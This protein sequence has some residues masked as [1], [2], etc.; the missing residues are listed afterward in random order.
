[1]NA[2][3]RKSMHAEVVSKIV[4]VLAEAYGLD[5]EKDLPFSLSDDKTRE[6]INEIAFD[7]NSS[8]G[9]CI[10]ETNIGL[11]ACIIGMASAAESAKCKTESG[12]PEEDVQDDNILS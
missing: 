6:I 12:D 2:N 1:M 3:E 10:M 9:F 8:F 11:S 4:K 7:L 5:V